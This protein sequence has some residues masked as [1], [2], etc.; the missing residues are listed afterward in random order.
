VHTEAVGR[1]KSPICYFRNMQVRP[2]FFYSV[3]HLL[4]SYCNRVEATI[5]LQKLLIRDEKNT[6]VRPIRPQL[7]SG[8][9]APKK[10]S[11]ATNEAIIAAYKGGARV[12]DLARQFGVN[13]WTINHRITMAGVERNP[14]SMNEEQ[15]T[16]AIELRL[17]GLSFNRISAR[18]PVSPHTIKNEIRSRG[19]R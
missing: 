18:L 7:E 11:A 6:V 16:Q 9:T 14:H 10:L 19:V 13:K 15:I 8:R 1:E 4:Q 12:A 5:R 2:I 3:V 17:E